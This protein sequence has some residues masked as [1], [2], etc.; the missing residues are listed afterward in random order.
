MFSFNMWDPTFKP[1]LN[2]NSFRLPVSTH[3]CASLRMVAFW[4]WRS[5]VDI[6]KAVVILFSFVCSVFSVAV[7]YFKWIHLGQAKVAAVL[8]HY[9][10]ECEIG[11]KVP[12]L[13]VP[14]RAFSKHLTLC[15]PSHILTK[16]HC[17]SGRGLI[18]TLN[19]FPEPVLIAGGF[20]LHCLFFF[21]A[22]PNRF[23]GFTATK[24][25]LGKTV[26]LVHMSRMR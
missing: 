16:A 12:A 21:L 23:W 15:V 11:L 9:Y 4:K 8:N 2:R 26:V 19:A 10:Y 5:W 24:C 13:K 3:A 17:V 20:L 18:N 1:L 25:R 7:D 14:E 6:V 22:H